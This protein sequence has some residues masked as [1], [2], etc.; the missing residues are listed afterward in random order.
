MRNNFGKRKIWRID[1]E[2]ALDD[3][4]IWR[5]LSQEFVRLFVRE[6]SQAKDLAYLTRSEELPELFPWRSVGVTRG[7]LR[8]HLL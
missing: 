8:A 4:Q 5:K 3:L 6:I 7:G 2:V 1:V